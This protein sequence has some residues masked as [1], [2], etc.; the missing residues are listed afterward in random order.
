[1]GKNRLPRKEAKRARKLVG[2]VIYLK[3]EEERVGTSSYRALR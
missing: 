3:T 2:R 1:M